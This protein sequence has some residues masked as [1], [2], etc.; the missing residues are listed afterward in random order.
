M[1]RTAR[2]LIRFTPP[3]TLS[4]NE[5][6]QPARAYTV[7]TDEEE[8]QGLSFPAYRQLRTGIVIMLP[9]ER[10]SMTL[11]QAVSIDPSEFDAAIQR[12]NGKAEQAGD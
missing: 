1:N 11:A 6:T 7:E 4:G 5:G 9:P 12:T 8:L 2:S 10:G 3:F